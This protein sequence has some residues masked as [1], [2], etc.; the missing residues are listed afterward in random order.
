M[1]HRDGT[2]STTDIAGL[3]LLVSTTPTTSTL[4]GTINQSTNT[5]WRNN[6]SLDIAEVDLLDEMEIQWRE[7]TRYGGSAPDFIL[8]GDDFLDAYRRGQA[9]DDQPSDFTTAEIRRAASA[10]TAPSPRCT[11]RASN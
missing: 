6:V 5:F 7:C 1:L 11:S 8:V 4:V 9:S 2:Q 10:S 3:D